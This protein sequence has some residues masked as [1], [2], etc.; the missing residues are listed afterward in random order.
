MVIDDD[1]LCIFV[2]LPAALTAQSIKVD[3]MVNGNVCS[4]RL[5]LSFIHLILRALRMSLAVTGG[6]LIL[7]SCDTA[8]CSGGPPMESRNPMARWASATRLTVCVFLCIPSRGLQRRSSRSEYSLER[9]V[10]V[11][12]FH[13]ARVYD[14][15]FR[16]PTVHY[17]TS[18]FI[19]EGSISWVS[20]EVLVLSVAV[21]YSKTLVLAEAL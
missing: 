6:F 18:E 14:V 12:G 10:R 9:D 7:A 16:S 13:R 17:H 20:E 3:V 15:V 2:N 5:Y 4:S 8:A 1:V 19:V 21:I 11:R